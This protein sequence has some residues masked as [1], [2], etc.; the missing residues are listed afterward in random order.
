VLWD[1]HFAFWHFDWFRTD[2]SLGI[3]DPVYILCDGWLVC[4]SWMIWVEIVV[5]SSEV[6]LIQSL[7]PHDPRHTWK[8]DWARSTH[9]K[10]VQSKGKCLIEL[11]PSE[12]RGPVGLPHFWRGFTLRIGVC[13]GA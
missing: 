13:S 2:G 3:T 5:G 1:E 9:N 12:T 8:A 11:I 4:P 6:R 10:N 7:D